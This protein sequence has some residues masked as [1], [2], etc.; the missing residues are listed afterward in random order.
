MDTKIETFTNIV[1]IV[2]SYSIGYWTH[3]ILTSPTNTYIS[4][5]IGF[6]TTIIGFLIYLGILIRVN[7]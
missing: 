1:V 7:R 3:C 5:L 6:G 4:T 2:S